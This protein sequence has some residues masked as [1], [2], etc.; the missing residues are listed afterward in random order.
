MASFLERLMYSAQTGWNAAR[1]AWNSPSEPETDFQCQNDIYTLYWLYY[2][3][4]IF[5]QMTAAF[6]KKYKQD[7]RLYRYIDNL[8]NP[9]E[10]LVEF[11]VASM[12]PG[13]LSEDGLPFK[14]GK[15]SA[16]PFSE[17][18]PPELIDAVSQIW[19]W[20]NW[21]SKKSLQVRLCAIAGNIMTEIIDDVPS[22][23]VWLDLIWPTKIKD[24]DLDNRGNVKGYV[25]EYNAYDREQEEYYLYRKEV[26]QEFRYFRDGQPHDYGNGAVIPNPYGFVPAVW[27][28]QRDIGKDHGV[29]V[30]SGLEPLMDK[31]NGLASHVVDYCHEVVEAPSV[32]WG[33][34]GIV[35][36]ARNAEKQGPTEEL[37]D[38]QRTQESPMMLAGP[39]GGH[40]EPLVGNLDLAGVDIQVKNL[41]D[42]IEKRKPELVFNERIQELDLSGIAI[43]RIMSNVTSRVEEAQEQYDQQNIKAWQ[44]AVAIAGMRA[45]SGAW[46]PLNQQQQKF[47]GYGLDSYERGLLDMSIAE[48]PLL[49]STKTEI[50]QEK[51]IFWQGVDAAIQAGV[52]LEL[53]LEDEGWTPEKLAR[54]QAAQIEKEAQIQR[55]QRL[56]QEDVIPETAQ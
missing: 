39:M 17:K 25:L 40:V 9:C 19:Q 14:N 2:S 3:N 27:T 11:Y 28:K 16:I 26:D 35:M 24:L 49:P 29:S 20:S 22:G 48:R 30:I 46:G 4:R 56:A 12:Y 38:Q 15:P 6:W 10:E 55:D 32:L 50:A 42:R 34:N 43:Q 47:V 36:A 1:R 33:G 8:Y 51:M 37:S 21:A 13:K 18:T 7:N 23:K 45:S 31:L 5:D 52:P 54:L 53:V 44:M 41:V